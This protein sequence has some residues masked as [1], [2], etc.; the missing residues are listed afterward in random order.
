MHDYE[1]NKRKVGNKG[2]DAA[3]GFLKENKYKI[4]DRNY[5]SKFGEIDIIAGDQKYTVFVE[6]RSKNTEF[7]GNAEESIVKKK[8]K[9]ITLTAM[10]YIQKNHLENSPVRFDVVVINPDNSIEIIKN[11]FDAEFG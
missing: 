7:Y 2:E 5:R 9:R 6:V 4:L 1:K 10:T 3:V 11:A 8:K